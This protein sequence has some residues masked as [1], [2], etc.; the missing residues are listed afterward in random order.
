MTS[1]FYIKPNSRCPQGQELLFYEPMGEA[2]SLPSISPT[3][4]GQT[5][6]VIGWC[7]LRGGS[8]CPVTIQWVRMMG[9]EGVLAI[10]GDFGLW[11][12]GLKRGTPCLFLQEDQLDGS[13]FS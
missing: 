3:I 10:G 1:C 8:A 13:L 11:M 9:C 4:E 6:K 12:P 7:S 5:Q 2:R